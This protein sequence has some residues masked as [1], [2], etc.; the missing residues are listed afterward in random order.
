MELLK[1]IVPHLLAGTVIVIA[2][3]YASLGLLSGYTNHSDSATVPNF[4]G[5]DGTTLNLD[6]YSDLNVVINDSVFLPDLPAGAILKQDPDPETIV[7][8]GRTVY[9]QMNNVMPESTRVPRLVDMSPRQARQTMAALGF[10]EGDPVI[11]KDTFAV[12]LGVRCNGRF[13]NS[14]DRIDKGSA[15]QLVLGDGRPRF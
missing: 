12:V 8:S 11:V 6:Q 2:I 7:K 14:G 15:L 13:V 1:R 10:D 9:L 5:L 4:V 3:F